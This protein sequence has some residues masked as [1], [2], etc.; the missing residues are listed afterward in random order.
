MKKPTPDSVFKEYDSGLGFNNQI[1]L[2][3]IVEQNENFFIDKQ[4][5][6]VQ[7]NG[8]STPTMNYC[9]RTVSFSVAT[10]LS[11]NIKMQ[12]H[13]LCDCPARP[14]RSRSEWQGLLQTSLKRYSSLTR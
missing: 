8:N 12:G 9:K 1:H 6:G 2:N 13:P 4:W 10:I 14:R 5:E 7:T 3:E 11:D